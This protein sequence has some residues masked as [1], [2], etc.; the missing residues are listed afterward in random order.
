VRGDTD[1]NG[2]QQQPLKAT[3]PLFS[4]YRRRSPS[5]LLSFSHGGRTKSHLPPRSARQK[6]RNNKEHV[7]FCWREN[8][9]LVRRPRPINSHKMTKNR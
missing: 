7:D 1:L 3:T 6:F 8:V 5:K 2:A 4:G 9:R